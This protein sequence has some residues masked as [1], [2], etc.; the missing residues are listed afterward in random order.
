MTRM[1]REP[2]VGDQDKLNRAAKLR[3]EAEALERE[4]KAETQR[5][6]KNRPVEDSDFHATFYEPPTADDI[7]K[8]D[9]D[10]VAKT[11][12]DYS[13]LRRRSR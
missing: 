9:E 10:P 11:I 5:P 13:P 1:G 6:V 2:S 12:R 4:A 8:E 7:F 3:Q